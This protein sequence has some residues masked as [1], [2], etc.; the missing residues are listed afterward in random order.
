MIWTFRIELL[1][2]IY[3]EEAWGVEMEI[4]STS[5]LEGLHLAIQDAVEFD[6]DHLYEFYISRSE[7]SNSRDIVRFDD[8]NGGIYNTTIEELYPLDKDKKLFYMFDYG[9]SW[10]FKLSKT[11]KKP[12][13][14][15]LG[16]DY[17]RIVAEV[18]TKPMQY[19]GWEE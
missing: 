12:Q 7:N 3:A 18:G 1:F 11:R 15:Q 6:N 5:T 19:P 17:P 2:G 13:D 14:I 10:L 8:E 4:D 9:D 16:V